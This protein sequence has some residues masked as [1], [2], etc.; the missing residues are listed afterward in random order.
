MSFEDL[1]KELEAV[2]TKLEQPETTLDE[3]VELFNKGIELSK[4]CV[5][6]LQ[7]TKG[8]VVLL[9]K[10]LDTVLAEEF[11]PLKED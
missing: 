11:D 5:E 2:S 6:I 8:K 3:G 10:E 7:Q 1:I 4:K 9:K